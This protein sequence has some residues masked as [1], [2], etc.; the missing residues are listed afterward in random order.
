[1]VDISINLKERRE[2][3]VWKFEVTSSIKNVKNPY[4]KIINTDVEKFKTKQEALNRVEELKQELYNKYAEDFAE[5]NR[6]ITLASEV[7]AEFK[8]VERSYLF[9]D[10]QYI[11]KKEY[12]HSFL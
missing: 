5:L 3:K 1:M 10:L 2:L 6:S 7:K 9:N 12:K 8:D 4:E 11:L